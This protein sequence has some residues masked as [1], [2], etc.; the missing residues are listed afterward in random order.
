MPR[1]RKGILQEHDKT[2]VN[3]LQ[4]VERAKRRGGRIVKNQKEKK[5]KSKPK[6]KENQN[7]S[8]EDNE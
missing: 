5:E 8:A 3:I 1:I 7:F 2:I 4:R 6:I